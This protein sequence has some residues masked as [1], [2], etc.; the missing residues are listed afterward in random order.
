ME[1]DISTGKMDT[2]TSGNQ[3]GKD[4]KV[5]ETLGKNGRS[6]HN[7]NGEWNSL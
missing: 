2:S 5:I 6:D 1:S 7:N 3:N 4:E